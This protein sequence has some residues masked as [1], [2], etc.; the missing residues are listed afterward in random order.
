VPGA[1]AAVRRGL[2]Y[3]V[4]DN[5]LFDA[6]DLLASAARAYVTAPLPPP[7]ELLTTAPPSLVGARRGAPMRFVPPTGGSTAPELTAPGPRPRVLV[8]RSTVAQPGRD[9]LMATV[10]AA[11]AGADVELV[12]VRPDHRVTRGLPGDVRTT[13]W[14]SFPDVLP[15]VAGIAHHGG[16]GTLLTAL[17]CG[18]PQ[19]VV[20]GAGDRRTNAGLLAA[21]GAGL[22]V[23]LRELGA[24]ALTRLAGDPDL[25]AAAG[26]VAAEMAAMPHPR[27]LVEHLVA[28]SRAAAPAAAPAPRPGTGRTR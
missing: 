15:A 27:E 4:V 17:S 23:E 10:V 14:L 2:P 1:C 19:L 26:E 22:A 12:L 3:V 28:L 8:S 18:T 6:E 20:P 16:A 25:R 9:R 5:S 13:G 21:R 11:G 24:A 7:A